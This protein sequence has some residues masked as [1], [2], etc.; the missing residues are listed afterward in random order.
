MR[1][2][3]LDSFRDNY[4]TT[5]DDLKKAEQQY[6]SEMERLAEETESLQRRIE[7]A[8]AAIKTAFSSML[9]GGNAYYADVAGKAPSQAGVGDVVATTGGSY[10]IGE[11][12]QEGFTENPE[13]QL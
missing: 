11:K 7:E 9:G 13:T 2:D 3:I 4:E 12:G 5:A 8:A 1:E 6:Q 10:L